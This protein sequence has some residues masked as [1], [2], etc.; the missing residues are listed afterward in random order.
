[1][2]NTPVP[3]LG[4]SCPA[5]IPALR[6]G[7][8]QLWRIDADTELADLESQC[9]AELSEAELE[10]GQRLRS[11]QLRHRF[12]L[13]HLASRRILGAYLSRSSAEL[14]FHYSATGKPGL[15]APGTRLEFNLSTTADLTL[16]AVRLEDPLGVDCELIRERVDPIGIA[17]RMFGDLAAERLA[18][19]GDDDRLLAF[20]T[21]WTELE[22]RVKRD[23]R[24]LAGYR[25]PDAPDIMVQH[26][27]PRA[28]AICALAGR[29]LP[30]AQDWL[31][32]NWRPV[33]E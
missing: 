30:P 33:A 4:W 1:M 19:L 2:T 24:G 18:R 26:A 15:S 32:F 10:R 11:A 28:D 17:R 16:L 3:E 21:A 8:L 22:A 23:G 12:L 31:T 6:P 5:R 9:R 14:E 27:R 13:S 7:R 29:A 25:D 20:Y